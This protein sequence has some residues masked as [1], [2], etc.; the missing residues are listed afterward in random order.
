MPH[1]SIITATYNRPEVL[2]WAIECVR[3]QT[4]QD[5]EHII[6]G[7][8]CTDGTEA[9]V[10][11]IADP[12]IRFV[13]RARNFGEQSGPNNDGLALARGER[14]AFLNHDDLWL[15]DHLT[16]LIAEIDT[17]G[18]DLV[19]A[20]LVSIDAVGVPRCGLTNP[21][22]RYKP[23]HFVPASLWLLRRSLATELKGWRPAN[24]I[25]AS[26]P[27]QDFLARAWKQGK[28]IACAPRITALILAS[29]GRPRA[30]VSHDGSQ[31]EELVRAMQAADFRERLLTRMVLEA[32]REAAP[33]RRRARGWRGLADHTVDQLLVAFGWQPS[34]VRNFLAGKQKGHWITYMRE[35]RGLPRIPDRGASE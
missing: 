34:A 22:L 25:H 6:I 8:A 35:F 19:Y 7:D 4:Y 29:G 2:R 17:L 31:H 20:P 27:S 26:N 9:L 28:L 24:T 11:G 1:V 23:S 3:R 30:Y 32:E 15:P 10:R 18:A 13:N 33:M 21:K 12:R 16:S 5:W 14:V